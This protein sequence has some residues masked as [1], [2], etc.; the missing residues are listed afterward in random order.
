MQPNL[1][2]KQVVVA[3]TDLCVSLK[4]QN[5]LLPSSGIG[6]RQHVSPK[7]R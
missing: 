3:V 2:L 5:L 7:R 1:T 6:S 4:D